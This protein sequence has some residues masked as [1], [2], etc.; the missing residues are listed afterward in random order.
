MNK[1]LVLIY[2]P[3][4]DEQYDCLIPINQKIGVIK[5]HLIKSINEMMGD[6]NYINENAKLYS[7]DTSDNYDA[8]IY[9][10]DSGIKNGA[11]LVLM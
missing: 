7:K 5:N 8:D 10:K 3:L 1:V 11:K 9:V 4:L 2:V 6:G